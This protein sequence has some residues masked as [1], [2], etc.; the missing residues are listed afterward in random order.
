MIFV[1][2]LPSLILRTDF[3]TMPENVSANEVNATS[4]TLMWDPPS[5]QGIFTIGF[6]RVRLVPS[7]SD[8]VIETNMTQTF[9]SG[10][11]PGI[12]YFVTVAAVFTDPL[13][14]EEVEVES[15]SVL[16]NTSVTGLT[17]VAVVH[18]IVCGYRMLLGHFIHVHIFVAVTL[19][20]TRFTIWHLSW[21]V[22]VC[23]HLY[24]NFF[25]SFFVCLFV[26]LPVC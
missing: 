1:L 15:S 5:F 22:Y 18:T 8:E 6:Y 25:S 26:C 20:G 17:P 19:K 24:P 4:A 23:L 14:E 11:F 9:V 13:S 3:P 2:P 7:P 12:E 16:F 21:N 10:L